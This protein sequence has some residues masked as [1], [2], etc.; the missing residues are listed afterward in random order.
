MLKLIQEIIY[1][2]TGKSNIT[3]DTDFVKDLEL[4]SFDV[5]NI[6]CAFEEYFD[7]T[8]PTRDV[9]K[10]HQVKVMDLPYGK[11]RDKGQPIDNISN[12]DS[13]QEEIVYICDSEQMRYANLLFA[14]KQGM[15]K[16]VGGSEFQVTKRTIA[17]TKL[18]PEDEV[19]NIRVVTE[20]QHIVL[21]TADGFFLRFPAAEVTEK[22][23]G[24]IGVRGIRLKKDDALTNVYLF[25]EGTECKISYHEK[26]VTLNRLKLAKRDGTGT[27][28]RG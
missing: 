21:Q 9:W 27:K 14:T 22:K 6:V 15:V 11:F 2:V 19:V 3:D 10:M 20:N 16:K 25:E 7:V 1:N 23:K 17:A 8:I 13:T 5:M 26:E 18:Q 4:N 28:Y 24:A 12:Y